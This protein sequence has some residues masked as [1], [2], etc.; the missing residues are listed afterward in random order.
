MQRPIITD[1]SEKNVNKGPDW[2]IRDTYYEEN[3]MM[4][5]TGGFLSGSDYSLTVRTAN[6]EALKTAAQAIGEFIRVEFSEYTQGSNMHGDVDRYISDGIAVFID[7]IKVH[8]VKQ[9]EIY[10]EE[11]FSP[12][13]MQP[14]YNIFVKLEL[15][16]VDYIQA[17][18]EMLR[19]LRDK[20]R[21]EG[22]TEAKE[23]AQ[24]LLEELKKEAQEA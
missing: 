13:D 12:R 24:K 6:A 20:F 4:Y 11:L 9:K 23:K 5:F 17:K 3:G 16:M 10:Y 19:R 8:G 7:R 15:P 22:N 14:A 21:K 18:A 2:V 1:S